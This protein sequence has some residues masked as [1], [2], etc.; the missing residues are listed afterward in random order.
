MSCGASTGGTG[1]SYIVSQRYSLGLVQ[2][3]TTICGSLYGTPHELY[4]KV[5]GKFARIIKQLY[6]LGIARW[7]Y[8][9]HTFE[10]LRLFMCECGFVMCS[11]VYL[12]NMCKRFISES[13]Y[14]FHYENMYKESLY[15]ASSYLRLTPQ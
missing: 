8:N 14:K 7:R 10:V 2:R 3:Q 13:S 1:A 9:K 6:Y 4:G 12:G 15:G 11:N 5:F